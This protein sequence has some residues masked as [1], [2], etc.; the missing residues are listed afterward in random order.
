VFVVKNME[1]VSRLWV[2][3]FDVALVLFVAEL[4]AAAG[5]THVLFIVRLTE[6]R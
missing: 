2:F 5:L 6:K 3:V 1:S 4:E